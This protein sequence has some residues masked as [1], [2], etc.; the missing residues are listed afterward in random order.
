MA[1]K[2]KNFNFFFK[3]GIKLYYGKPDMN[4][5]D[6]ISSLYLSNL[7]WLFM[8]LTAKLILKKK[9]NMARYRN[10]LQS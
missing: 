10:S 1:L 9:Q 8:Y 6:I 2:T 7:V 4:W 3:F 5:Q